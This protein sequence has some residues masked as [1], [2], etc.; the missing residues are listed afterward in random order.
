MDHKTWDRRFCVDFFI[1]LIGVDCN[2]QYNKNGRATHFLNLYQFI[3][4]H[5][6]VNLFL[7]IWP[8]HLKGFFHIFWSIGGHP[9]LTQIPNL[10]LYPYVFNIFHKLTQLSIGLYNNKILCTKKMISM[11]IIP[12]SQLSLVGILQ[13]IHY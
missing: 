7:W 5:W 9:I 6:Y 2:H 8:N 11:Y 3:F 10:H 1:Y 12:I 4:S 13:N